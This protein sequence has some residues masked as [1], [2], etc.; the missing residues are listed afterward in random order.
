VFAFISGF[1]GE[2]TLRDQL[3]DPSTAIEAWKKLQ[4]QKDAESLFLQSRIYAKIPATREISEYKKNLESILKSDNIKAHKLLEEAH[5]KAPDDC[6]ILFHLG[7]DYFEGESYGAPQ[8]DYV[9]A[10]KY[11]KHA[12]ESAI[13]SNKT[14]RLEE[15]ESYLEE[16]SDI[17]ES[18][19]TKDEMLEP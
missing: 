19:D 11:F 17:D 8:R 13:K 16:L 14:F 10:K 3:M 18:Q 6:N 4:T 12:K 15:I 9:K 1:G 5:I 2:K 7:E